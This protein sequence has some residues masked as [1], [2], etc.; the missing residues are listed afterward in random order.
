V[1]PGEDD[2]PFEQF[3]KGEFVEEELGRDDPKPSTQA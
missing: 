2:D 3:V 1:V